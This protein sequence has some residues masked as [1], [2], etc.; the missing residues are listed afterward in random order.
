MKEHFQQIRPE[1]TALMC[2]QACRLVMNQNV[3][4]LDVVGA[5]EFFSPLANFR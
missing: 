3:A 2:Q 5:G 1:S 4:V